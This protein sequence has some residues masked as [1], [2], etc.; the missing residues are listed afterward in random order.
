MNWETIEKE[1]KK[2]FCPKDESPEKRGYM[3]NWFIHDTITGEHLISFFKERF[4]EMIGEDDC[5]E[6]GEGLDND[7]EEQVLSMYETMGEAHSGGYNQAKKEM[8]DKVKT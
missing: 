7:L 4:L 3:L 2:K 8:R 6:E 1:F 5:Y